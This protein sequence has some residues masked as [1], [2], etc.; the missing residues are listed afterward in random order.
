MASYTVTYDGN[1]G[2]YNGATTW[3][4]T[5]TL[6]E[7]YHVWFGFFTREG[8]RFVGW[9]ESPD[10]TGVSW[11]HYVDQDWLWQYTHDTVLYAQWEPI[12]Y[13]LIYNG[14]GSVHDI[15]E[16]YAE[17][18][19]QVFFDSEFTVKDNMFTAQ[20]GYEFAGW[21]TSPDGTA[22]DYTNWTGVWNWDYDLTLYAQWKPIS[23]TTLAY[24][25]INGVWT[26]HKPYT[27]VGG[28]W[29]EIIN[30]KQY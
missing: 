16:D 25:K 13:N 6:G 27:K 21:N 4:D 22:W 11:D 30:V 14:N 9:N 15:G 23:E 2:T 17:F 28:I 24:I 7:Y 18:A 1:G 5:A 3:S 29:K 10:G 8:Y 26:P 12:A 20:S 19:E